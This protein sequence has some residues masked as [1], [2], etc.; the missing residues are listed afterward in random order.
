MQS[1]DILRFACIQWEHEAMETDAVTG[2]IS[3]S[4]GVE[5]RQRPRWEVAAP[6]TDVLGLSRLAEWPERFVW[7]RGGRGPG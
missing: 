7:I 3:T 2:F 4:A 1:K 6:S 5:G